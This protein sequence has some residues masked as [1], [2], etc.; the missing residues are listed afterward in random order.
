MKRGPLICH[1]W[2]SADQV[3]TEKKIK[4][5]IALSFVR[6]Y[7]TLSGHAYA[8]T[9]MHFHGSSKIIPLFAVWR[10]YPH[11][12][13]T[14]DTSV[15]GSD[16]ACEAHTLQL[17]ALRLRLASA[18]DTST[19]VRTSIPGAAPVELPIAVNPN[20]TSSET[21]VQQLLA[22]LKQA[23]TLRARSFSPRASVETPSISK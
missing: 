20:S 2:T 15:G 5:F 8:R 6:F 3:P 17:A 19:E 22:A 23:R 14:L 9:Q 4:Q 7:V 18:S 21:E 1:L 12:T 11:A 16:S 13:N 10:G